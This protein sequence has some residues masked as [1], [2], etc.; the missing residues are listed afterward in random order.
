VL[1]TPSFLFWPLRGLH[2]AANAPSPGRP[3]APSAPP[4]IERGLAKHRQLALSGLQQGSL[5]RPAEPWVTRRPTERPLRRWERL[6]DDWVSERPR[7]AGMSVARLGWGPLHWPVGAACA[8]GVALGCGFT[9]HLS[10][11]VH[12]LQ[13]DPGS[14]PTRGAARGVLHE[15]ADQ[16]Q[17][18]LLD[19]WVSN[20]MAG[21]NG[22]ANA[23]SAG[24][25]R[26]AG[27][28]RCLGV[29]IQGRV[30]LTEAMSEWCA[31]W[32]RAAHCAGQ[33]LFIGVYV[34]LASASL[35]ISPLLLVGAH[36][37]V[38]LVFLGIRALWDPALQGRM[39]A[40]RNAVGDLAAE[41]PAACYQSDLR[42]LTAADG[43][44]RDR[45]NASQRARTLY[46]LANLADALGRLGALLALQACGGAYG[47]GIAAAAAAGS[48]AVDAALM[49]GILGAGQ[50]LL[51]SLGQLGTRGRTV[52]Q[53]LQRVEAHF[54]HHG[55]EASR[56][57]DI[58]FSR[59]ELFQC[60]D[61]GAVEISL[62]AL[63]DAVETNRPGI[64]RIGGPAGAGKSTLTRYLKMAAPSGARLLSNPPQVDFAARLTGGGYSLPRALDAVEGGNLPPG[65]SIL[66]G[67]SLGDAIDEDPAVVRLRD[68][69]SRNCLVYVE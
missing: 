48:G 56:L 52:W 41:V 32:Q 23:V 63:V 68:G 38:H 28:L 12:R 42:S 58:D 17:D 16:L 18:G 54:A 59:L 55:D 27:N 50:T 34:G 20:V 69:S 30:A 65:V 44:R 61:Y 47:T 26:R 37:A 31:L 29:E 62:E 33:L 67:F 13:P 35:G 64:Y 24:D 51:L 49:R 57:T 9:D 46:R 5:R 66:D 4:P 25:A 53:K 36:L 11:L 21:C 43:R 15:L 14:G 8:C 3:L 2:R 19:I 39:F 7:G 10:L 45:A 60:D 22:A 1:S 40:A 6:H